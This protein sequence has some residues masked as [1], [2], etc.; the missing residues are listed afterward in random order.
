MSLPEIRQT[1]GTSDQVASTRSTNVRLEVGTAHRYPVENTI[2]LNDNA[3]I[4]YPVR[5]VQ[6]VPGGRCPPLNKRILSVEDT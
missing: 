6:V 5:F 2:Q 4:I 3:V 1:E